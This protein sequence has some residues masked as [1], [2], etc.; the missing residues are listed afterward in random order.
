MFQLGKKSPH[1][2][3]LSYKMTHFHPAIRSTSTEYLLSDDAHSDSPF[4][5]D[6]I[7]VEE[8]HIKHLCIFKMSNCYKS[9]VDS[10]QW[11]KPKRRGQKGLPGGADAQTESRCMWGCPQGRSDCKGH[12]RQ[13]EQCAANTWRLKISRSI[14]G[15]NQNSTQLQRKVLDGG[16]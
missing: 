7:L 10:V 13:R 1:Q 9:S 14:W 2:R 12:S 15:Y 8:A 4:P 6:S 3:V 5:R 16:E 11:G